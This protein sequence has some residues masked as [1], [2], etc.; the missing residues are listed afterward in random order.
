MKCYVKKK[1]LL[2]L[3][4]VKFSQSFS[5]WA[6][7]GSLLKQ[8][9]F[10][11]C[12]IGW[13]GCIWRKAPVML[14]CDR[15]LLVVITLERRQMQQM[16]PIICRNSNLSYIYMGICCAT[17]A[18]VSF[19]LCRKCKSTLGCNLKIDTLNHERCIQWSS[20]IVMVLCH[21]AT[22][23]CF[24]KKSDFFNVSK[25]VRTARSMWFY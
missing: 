10:N 18:T 15:W 23:T 22:K 16:W 25:T 14:M 24:R 1:M 20:D 21:A 3:Y 11:T 19:N 9:P 13:K 17:N 8:K 2:N 7:K 4:V 6:F 12:D 5:I